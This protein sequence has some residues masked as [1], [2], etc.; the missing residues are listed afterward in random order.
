MEK[1][2][3]Q[4]LGEMM[5]ELLIEIVNQTLADENANIKGKTPFF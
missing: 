1:N 5:R 3:S 2:A 4:V